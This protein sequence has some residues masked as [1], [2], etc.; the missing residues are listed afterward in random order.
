MGVLT[1][2][3]AYIVPLAIALVRANPIY[4]CS[5]QDQ[6]I[7][8]GSEDRDTTFSTFGESLT[9][10]GVTRSITKVADQGDS[11]V[12]YK[13]DSPGWPDPSTNK[14]VVAYA[15]TGKSNGETFKSEIRWLSRIQ[16]LLSEGKYNNRQWIV[17][18]GV[19]NKMDLL[20]TTFG[21]ALY[22]KMGRGDVAGCEADV[23][24][25]MALVVA[26]AKVYVDK[27]GV[28]HTDI[29]PGNILWDKDAT[30]PTLIDWGRADEVSSWTPAI[31]ARVRKQAED[32]HTK[33]ALK[34]CHDLR[35]LF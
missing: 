27:F 34:V 21:L 3:I 4:L 10:N 7:L 31:E 6:L 24:A 11:A 1:R 29:H 13:V 20:A 16:Q 9:L 15:K 30:D 25:K 17:F 33:G 18:H 22:Q 35:G 23:K 2:S 12:T 8:V 26:E 32:S 28:L 5:A 19:E 14:D